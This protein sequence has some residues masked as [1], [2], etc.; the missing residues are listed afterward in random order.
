MAKTR[1]HILTK[2]AAYLILAVLFLGG[3]AYLLRYRIVGWYLDGNRSAR[4][5]V[6]SEVVRRSEP[7]VEKG[8][9]MTIPQTIFSFLAGRRSEDQRES[10]AL[11]DVRAFTELSFRRR[12][13]RFKDIHGLAS[14]GGFNTLG[15]DIGVEWCRSEAVDVL[16]SFRVNVLKGKASEM[17]VNT[18]CGFFVELRRYVGQR[19]RENGA[20]AP[21]PWPAAAL[22]R[23]CPLRQESRPEAGIFIAPGQ[24]DIV[25]LK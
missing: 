17:R 16:A 22:P 21:G 20:P 5:T 13:L 2:A 24:L 4:E 7:S 11:K 3:L 1:R 23:S 12:W 25:L 6:I 19:A 9:K 15:A 18:K 10:D 8:V 14:V